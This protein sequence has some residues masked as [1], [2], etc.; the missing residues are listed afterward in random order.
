MALTIDW[1]GALATPPYRAK[2]T[3]PQADLTLVSGTLYELNIM[4]F[5]DELKS[6][7]D[8]VDG[9]VFGDLQ[10]HNADYT[11]AGVN[12]ADAVF[13]LSQVQFEDTASQYSV[14]LV[15]A[16]TDFFDVENDI[17]QPTP[18]VTVI[19]N[20]SA[21]LAIPQAEDAT[22]TRKILDNRETLSDGTTGNRVIYD[23]DDVTV[24][25]TYDVSDEDDNT[26]TLSP[27]DP[28]KKSQGY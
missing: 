5:W 22:I 13:C 7:E 10:A 2:V 27:G 17:L 18:L 21:G 24:F 20:N 19:S 28:A 1:T 25:R 23:D 15:G 4:D 8:D 3:I 26:I 6:R 11:I 14:R 9:I 12:Y 16:N